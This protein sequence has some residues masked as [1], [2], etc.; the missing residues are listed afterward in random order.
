MLN[1]QGL[2]KISS[3]HQK[4]KKKTISFS[5]LEASAYEDH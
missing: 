3:T 4:K 5:L 2:L 1:Q